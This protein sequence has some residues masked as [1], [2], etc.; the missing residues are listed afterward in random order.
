MLGM[1]WVTFQGTGQLRDCLVGLQGSVPPVMAFHLGSLGFLTPFTFE[2]FQTQVAQVIQGEW[3]ARAPHHCEHTCLLAV[4]GWGRVGP[5]L[6]VSGLGDPGVSE[7][8]TVPS[9]GKCGWVMGL[10]PWEKGGPWQVAVL[11]LTSLGVTCPGPQV[12]Q[13]WSS[14][15]D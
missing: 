8:Q 15:A 6:G 7:V 4:Q 9:T 2:N 14:G 13:L 3:H 1:R 5:H 10:S 12:T 11:L